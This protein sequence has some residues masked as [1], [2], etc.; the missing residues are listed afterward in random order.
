MTTLNLEAGQAQKELGL[1]ATELN[2]HDFVDLAREIAKLLCAMHGSCTMD[3]VRAHPALKDRQPSSSHAFGAIF[4]GK[5]WRMIGYEKSA[6]RTNRAR[7]I[8]RWRWQ[9]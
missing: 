2:N 4:N 5:G 3:D 9:P 7:R 1:Y 8:G 6:V